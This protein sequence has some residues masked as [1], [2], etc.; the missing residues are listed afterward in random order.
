[1]KTMKIIIQK[2]YEFFC[3]SPT[4]VVCV[5]LNPS[6]VVIVPLVLQ[7]KNSITLICFKRLRIDANI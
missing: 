7:S 4:F 5:Q 1:M 6:L 2:I 3:S